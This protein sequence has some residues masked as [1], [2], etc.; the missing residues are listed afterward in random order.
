MRAS[1]GLVNIRRIKKVVTIIIS[2]LL[3]AVAMQNECQFFNS[4]LQLLDLLVFE[5]QLINSFLFEPF[6]LLISIV[7]N[8]HSF[9]Q[10]SVILG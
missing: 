8:H 5:S 9:L 4:L 7:H 2:V 6:I 1:I 3:S 10:D